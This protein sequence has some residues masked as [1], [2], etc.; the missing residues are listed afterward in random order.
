MITLCLALVNKFLLDGDD[1]V[2]YICLYFGIADGLILWGLIF[3]L[4]K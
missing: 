4:I 3:E 1:D 2:Y